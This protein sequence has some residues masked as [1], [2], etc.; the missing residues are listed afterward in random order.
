MTETI[1]NILEISTTEAPKYEQVID[2]LGR[3]NATGKRKNA[4]ARVW[5]KKGT[6]KFTIN[7]I[8]AR[9]YL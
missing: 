4:I 7:G 6:G 1:K 8:D 5:I 9:K 2:S 3:S